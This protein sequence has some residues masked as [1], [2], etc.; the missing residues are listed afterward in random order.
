[1]GSKVTILEAANR[2]TGFADLE[3]SDALEKIMID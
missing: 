2:I 1:M 3:M